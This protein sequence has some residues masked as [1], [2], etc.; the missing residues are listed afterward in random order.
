MNC[1]APGVVRTPFHDRFNTPE[2]LENVR[3]SL[4]LQ[5]LGEPE[6]IA[7][8]ALFLG[9]SLSSFITGEVLQANGGAYFG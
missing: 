6:D 5:R 8:A 7:N 2:I 9:S 4:P 3:K 1:I